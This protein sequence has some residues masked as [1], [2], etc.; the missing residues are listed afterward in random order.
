MLVKNYASY[1][2]FKYVLFIPSKLLFS[3]NNFIHTEYRYYKHID[4]CNVCI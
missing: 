4:D 2:V 3:I 1:D